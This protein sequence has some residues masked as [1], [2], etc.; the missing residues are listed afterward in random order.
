MDLDDLLA[1]AAQDIPTPLES[2]RARRAMRRIEE[3][4]Q[5]RLTEGPEII[6]D[7]DPRDPLNADVSEAKRIRR[8]AELRKRGS[9]TW[10]LDRQQLDWSDE[11]LRIFGLA[12]VQACK[13]LVRLFALIHPADR[14]AVRRRLL[15]GW[16]T[17]SA[18]EFVC[19]V[20]LRDGS[21]SY[22]EFLVEILTDR[23]GQPTGIIATGQ[24]V[25]AS[26]KRRQE[27]ER[28]M[29]RDGSV[30]K[31]LAEVDA[32][33]GL[34]SRRA[35]TDEV[36]RAL[37]TGTGTLL[38][39]SASP[40][41]PPS[42]DVDRGPN[43]PLSAIAAKV[44]R[45]VVDSD[46]CG[47]LGRYEF[48]VL[49]PYTTFETATPKA[50][51]VIGSLRD[52]W[53]LAGCT[54]LDAFGGLVHYDYRLPTESIELL[55]DA[56]T[57]W[58]RAKHEDRPLHV[59]RQPPSAEERRDICRAGIRN[60]VDQSRFALYAQ[61]LRDLELNRTTRHEILLRVLDDVGRPTPPS[62]F[63]QLAEHVDEILAVDKWV[64][65]HAL[66]RIGHGPQTS[67]Y[68]INISGR[69]L[70]DPLLLDHI[71]S[72]VD[73]FGV[74]PEH[75]TVEITETAA[76]GNLIVARRFADGIRELGCQVALDDFG[77]GNTP[78]G[79]LTKL[80]VDLVKIDGSFI[81][82]LPESEPLQAV[83]QGLVQMCRKL[84]ILTA[85]ECVQD[86]ATLDLLREYGVDFAQG[87]HVGQ[88]EKLAVG[89]VPSASRWSCNLASQSRYGT[90]DLRGAI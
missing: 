50:E 27:D 44:L 6:S 37:R 63:L 10:D 65:N 40:Y 28:R 23:H 53:F 84:G 64:I 49:M 22:V 57:A 80:P 70:A 74:D 56:E 20:T 77:T 69:S 29:L 3:D 88:P 72:A 11:M 18:A 25:T 14:A 1:L 73:R 5:R 76:I 51:E 31:S 55:L 36:G 21:S 54:R 87:F 67:H 26:Q 45:D 19:R 9:I 47:L 35:F 85:A 60:A 52:T 4:Y 59:L 89:G 86:D 39:V 12:P 32:V 13:S 42:S 8:A 62:T 33:T 7:V 58:R 61:P 2:A 17:K 34:L 75:L 68:Q 15:T 38:V 79:F 30:Q 16:R 90:P 78:L 43:D 83:V 66:A 48:G 82:G 41:S 81:D 46:P 71:R 24:E